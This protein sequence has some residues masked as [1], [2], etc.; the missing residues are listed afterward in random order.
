[1]DHI[2]IGN[3]KIYFYGSDKTHAFYSTGYTER[4][5]K[6]YYTHFR[7]WDQYYGNSPAG[8]YFLARLDNGKRKRVYI[9]QFYR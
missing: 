2:T 3:T 9:N 5:A 4:K 1:M 8:P 7:T 6:L